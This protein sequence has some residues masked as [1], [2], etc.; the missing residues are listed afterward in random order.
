MGRPLKL[1]A[2]VIVALAVPPLILAADV[3]G[4]PLFSGALLLL[5]PASS[6]SRV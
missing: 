1:L 3:W 6:H 2:T 5:V 4:P